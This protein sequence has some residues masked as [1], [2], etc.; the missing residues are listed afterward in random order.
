VLRSQCTKRKSGQGRS[1]RIH[2]H[3]DLF[4]ELSQLEKTKEGREK[5]RQRT[6]VEH[7]LARISQRQD[8]KARY[9]GTRKNTFELRMIC[10]IQN[11]ERAQ[12]LESE[13]LKIAA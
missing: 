10:A 9:N 8:K 4:Q 6:G 12:Y 2:K 1:L 3:E 13:K 11:L 7:G 5:L